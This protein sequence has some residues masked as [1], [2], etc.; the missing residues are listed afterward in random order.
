MPEPMPELKNPALRAMAGLD[1]GED[2]LPELKTPAL[3][4]MAGYADDPQYD[5]LYAA[6]KKADAEP[7]GVLQ[8]FK[9]SYMPFGDLVHNDIKVGGR[10]VGNREYQE[11]QRRY[12]D[13]KASDDDIDA[14]AL[15]EAHQ[16][17]DERMHKTTAGKLV[18]E[19][20]GLSKIGAEATAGGALMGRVAALRGGVKAGQVLGSP[21]AAAAAPSAFRAGAQAFGQ[22]ALATAAAPGFYVPMAQQQNMKF[23]R[24]AN[25]ASGYAPAY[26]YG[27]ANMIVLGRLQGAGG[28][29]LRGFVQKGAGASLEMSVVDL[30]AELYDE[31]AKATGMGK[32][33]TDRK[34]AWTRAGRAIGTG[35]GK[36]LNDILEET[37]VQAL[38]FGLFG[39]MHS[40]LEAKAVPE[41]WQQTLDKLVEKG[42]PPELALRDID[43]VHKTAQEYLNSVETLE[44]R[45]PGKADLQELFADIKDPA[46]REYADTISEA[47]VPQ[48]AKAKPVEQPKPELPKQEAPKPEPPQPEAP[49]PEPAK[50]EPEK[51]DVQKSIE[52]AFDM[53]GGGLMDGYYATLAESLAKTGDVMKQ[54]RGAGTT[55]AKAWDAVRAKFGSGPDAQKR[56][57]AAAR[58]SD[59]TPAGWKDALNKAFAD[60]PPVAAAATKRPFGRRPLPVIEAPRP[61][62]AAEQ[63]AAGPVESPRIAPVEPVVRQGSTPDTPVGE[64]GRPRPSQ[65]RLGDGADVGHKDNLDH[66]LVTH[67]ILDGNGNK[68]GE[69]RVRVSGRTINLYWSGATGL[70]SGAGRATK[71][72]SQPFGAREIIRLIPEYLRLY[73]DALTLEYVAGEGRTRE[74]KKS[75][76]DMNKLRQKLGFPL[77]PE[78]P[79]RAPLPEAERASKWQEVYDSMEPLV[80]AETARQIADKEAGPAPEAAAAASPEPVRQPESVKAPE[81]APDSPFDTTLTDGSPV[82]PPA[83]AK[84]PKAG[85]KKPKPEPKAGDGPPQIGRQADGGPHEPSSAEGVRLAKWHAELLFKEIESAPDGVGRDTYLLNAAHNSRVYDAELMEKR[86]ISNVRERDIIGQIASEYRNAWKSGD[87]E[88]IAFMERIVKAHGGEIVG[89]PGDFVKFDGSKHVSEAPMFTDYAARVVRPG[90]DMKPQTAGYGD[91]P[92]EKALVEPAKEPVAAAAGPESAPVKKPKAGA[93]KQT[94]KPVEKPAEPEKAPAAPPDLK[95]IWAEAD[96]AARLEYARN[97]QARKLLEE[98]GV[99]VKSGAARAKAALAAGNEGGPRT[100][101]GADD[102]V[103]GFDLSEYLDRYKDRIPADELEPLRDKL[104]QMTVRAIAEKYGVSVGTAQARAQ[105]GYEKLKE[106][107]PAFAANDTVEQA[108]RSLAKELAK[109]KLVAESEFQDVT[110]KTD[111][112]VV[113]EKATAGDAT[114]SEVERREADDQGELGTTLDPAARVSAADLEAAA[115]AKTKEAPKPEDLVDDT[116]RAKSIEGVTRQGLK[117]ALPKMELTPAE[118]AFVRKFLNGEPVDTAYPPGTGAMAKLRFQGAIFAKMAQAR[119]DLVKGVKNLAELKIAMM[120]DATNDKGELVVLFAGV[121]VRTGLGSL[122]GK[123][124]PEGAYDGAGRGVSGAL[125]RLLRG[126]NPDAVRLAK[127]QEIDQQIAAHEADVAAAA[128]DFYLAVK[129]ETGQSYAK[130]DGD[131]RAAVD[132]LL[133]T[134]AEDIADT[135]RPPFSAYTKVGPEVIAA[136]VQFRRHIDKLSKTLRDSGMVDGDLDAAFE[137]NEGVYVKR[138]Y[139]AFKDAAWESKVPVEVQNR[140]KD[141][142]REQFMKS[143]ENAGKTIS[144]AELDARM[145]SLLVDGKAAE[146]PMEQL[147]RVKVLAKDISVLRHKKDIPEPIRALWGEIK[148]PLVNYV[149]SVGKIAHLLT[150]HNFMT[151]VAKEGYGNFLFD[152]DNLAAFAERF[153]GSEGAVQ[154][155][156]T[157]NLKGAA[158]DPFKPLAGYYTT[159]EIKQAMQAMF[160]KQNTS[161]LMSLYMKTLGAAKYAKTALNPA[162]H[163]HNA[164]GNLFFLLGNG[165]FNGAKYVAKAVRAV[166]DDSPAGRAYWRTLAE[167]G[168]AEEGV[169]YKEF[170]D[171]MRRA[172]GEQDLAKLDD[173]ITVSLPAVWD[174]LKKVGKWAGKLYQLEDVVPKIMAFEAEKAQYA[175]AYPELSEAELTRKAAEIVRDT[176]PT[177]SK[178]VNPARAVK[179]LPVAPFVG[180]YTEM[181]RATVATIR[182]SAIELRDPRTRAIGARRLTGV[183]AA[184]T[185]TAGLSL[186]TRALLGIG[187]DEEKAVRDMLPAK[188]KDGRLFYFGRDDKGVPRYVNMSKTDPRANVSDALVAFWRGKDAE[189]GALNA[190]DVLMKPFAGEEVAVKPVVDVMRNNKKTVFGGGE[191]GRVY[192]EADAPEDK[193]L[194]SARHVGQAF[195]PGAYSSGRKILFG[196]TGAVEPGTGK[197]YDPLNE[198]M[199]TFGQ[200]PESVPVEEQLRFRVRDFDAATTDAARLVNE[201]VNDKAGVTPRQLY[202]AKRRAEQV[203]RDAFEELKRHVDAAEALRVPRATVLKILKEAGASQDEIEALFAGRVPPIAPEPA[204]TPLQ[205]SR[206]IDVRKMNAPGYQPPPRDNSLTG[207]FGMKLPGN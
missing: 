58:E 43:G 137:A 1:G 44:G 40:K 15:Y 28:Q 91:N 133:H 205:R 165:H 158:L 25:A 149:N 26:A 77:A 152:K 103:L 90:V 130:A 11:A 190:T 185:L 56:F 197:G 78:T 41:K 111:D 16:A 125:K 27:V 189:E 195:V 96:N 74:G 5:K 168:L 88:A 106:L 177:A 201:R 89:R 75:S 134:K 180:F 86:D 129:S 61:E 188:D 35:N 122:F 57:V 102:A 48:K 67:S 47:F 34:S 162:T 172:W 139:Q 39:A 17:A 30:G 142:L 179:N 68:V 97:P 55:I 207:P 51:P 38:S 24:D 10:T 192:N 176:F 200:R 151:R 156:E 95:K 124:R 4:A 60:T 37:A 127:E 198:L 71:G 186:L 135:V 164:A 81:P 66:P 99:D 64:A 36:E 31:A 109:S 87:P 72:G 98:A 69:T 181:V 100:K 173:G 196:A 121:P 63:T 160:T 101:R 104:A 131:Y 184:A 194:K 79:A 204:G 73:P 85:Q 166:M 163:G 116:P 20:G 126:S 150:T 144:D 193:A 45:A 94:S 84:K 206:Q 115:A 141:W 6:K 21:V 49:Q 12:Q 33:V 82:A 22:K 155:V 76:Y 110:T 7:I 167:H 50:Q 187:D 23:G 143:E 18:S 146:N 118:D 159:K 157:D 14:I 53:F 80:G 54:E 117:D 119:P 29:G 65:L 105:A 153:P 59:Q 92:N 161:A 203:R 199:A 107:D 178:V 2:P 3:R 42:L 8:S 183:A 83:K 93:K 114:M 147:S 108:R 174:A 175:K 128:R 70:S 136:V 32:Y 112:A 145:R 9:R 46:L 140:F 13:G 52:Q 169:M 191:R 182:Q 148:D 171:M 154:L 138:E 120:K 123:A 202:D 132:M 113:V 62:V 19:L 170:G